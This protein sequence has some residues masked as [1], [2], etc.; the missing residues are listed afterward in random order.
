[1]FRT[2]A[3]MML[4]LCVCSLPASAADE[5]RT[6]VASLKENSAVPV[7][8]FDVSLLAAG[9]RPDVSARRLFDRPVSRPA[10]LPVL[11]AGLAALQV[12][13]MYSTRQALALGAH[14]TNPAMQGIVANPVAFAAV[15]VATAVIPMLIAERM[16]K[17][18]RFAAIVTMV[19][20]NSAMAMVAANNA[21][22]LHQLR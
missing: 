21:R 5:N 9:S 14:E 17:T 2:V 13:D 1:M 6:G 12:F 15:K 20:A 18:H 11:Y 8:V 10:A 7:T 16:W 4:T 3:A 19:V 22:V